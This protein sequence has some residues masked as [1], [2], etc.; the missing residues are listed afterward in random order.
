MQPHL[1]SPHHLPELI[2]GRGEE[3]AVSPR[4]RDQRGPQW[5]AAQCDFFLSLKLSVSYLLRKEPDFCFNFREAHSSH[6]G[7]MRSP[8]Y[9][10]VWTRDSTAGINPLLSR[11]LSSPGRGEWRAG[12]SL[13]GLHPRPLTFCKPSMLGNGA[14]DLESTGVA[15]ST[16]HQGTA[17]G[18][19][20]LDEDA[21]RY[22]HRPS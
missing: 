2:L 22:T 20:I 14:P 12:V 18:E 8:P 15:T 9:P 13:G 3:G 19:G 7:R 6:F 11:P 21:L 4:S 10:H 1:T 17:E 16:V 5:A